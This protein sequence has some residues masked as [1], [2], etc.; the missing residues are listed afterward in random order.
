MTIQTTSSWTDR[1]LD[2]LGVEHEAPS[3]DHLTRLIDAQFRAVPFENVTSLLRR[4]AVPD[5]PV[6]GVDLEQLLDNWEAKR[7]G[8]VC[9]ETVAMFRQ[10]L[11]DLGYD[12]RLGLAQISSPDGHQVLLVT[13]DGVEWLVDVGTGSPV[14]R[15]ISLDRPDAVECAGV[16][17]RFRADDENPQYWIQERLIDGEWKRTCHYDLGPAPREREVFAYQKHHR[18][19]ES[20]VVDT[21]RMVCWRDNIGYSIS[22][23]ELTTLK[24]GGKTVEILNDPARYKEVAANLYGVPDLPIEQAMAQRPT[25]AP[26]P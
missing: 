5:G 15:P 13:L 12:V 10:L 14:F 19:G 22:G 8:G 21:L 18:Y 3:L 23:N 2:L 26:L 7:G 17:F 6:P 4:G 1:Y 11:I 20:W 9:F 25:F 24:N 16:Q